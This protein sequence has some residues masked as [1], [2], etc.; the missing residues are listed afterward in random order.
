MLRHIP[1]ELHVGQKIIVRPN[2]THHPLD[3]IVTSGTK[4]SLDYY[5]EENLDEYA[6]EDIME[7]FMQAESDSIE[8]AFAELKED[9]ITIEEIQ[10]VRIKFLSDMAN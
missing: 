2:P 7:Y 6:R 9:D 4:V 1:E 10:L 3:A 8:E 5:L